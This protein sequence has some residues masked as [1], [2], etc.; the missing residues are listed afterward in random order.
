MMAATRLRLLLRRLRPDLCIAHGNR[1]M[2]LLRGAGADPVV[3]VL[4]NYTM[5]CRGAAAVFYP[6]LDLKRYAISQGV[7]D[8]CLHHIPSMVEVAGSP[9]A[10]CMR[11]PPVIGA[12]GR[13][14]VKKGFDVFI[15]ALARLRSDGAAFRAI[16]AGEGPERAALEHLANNHGLQDVLAFPGWVGDKSSFFADIDVFCL[17]S[18]HEPFG[19]VLLEAM[20]RAM[21]IVAT[22]SEGPSEILRDGTHADLVPR[23]DA[24]RL[25][26][27]LGRMIADPER[28][29]RLGQSAYR[30]ARETFDLARVAARL[31]LAV[32]RVV[33]VRS[34][35]LIGVTA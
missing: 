17:P 16:L 22:D 26:R 18:R 30:H 19:I 28:A 12:M 1:A 15:T 20:A 9:P 32:R 21:P 34:T 24:E 35:S 6:T 5:R 33:E 25:T 29:A 31:D 4:P 2:S 7:A 3:A 10:H 11:H 13:F 27:A 8:G 14:V 23:G